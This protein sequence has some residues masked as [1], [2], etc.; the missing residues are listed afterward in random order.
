MTDNTPKK[1]RAGLYAALAVAVAGIGWAVF[2]LKSA[3]P[4]PVKIVPVAS[5]PAAKPSPATAFYIDGCE[6][7]ARAINLRAAKRD[8]RGQAALGVDPP[9]GWCECTGAILGSHFEPETVRGVGEWFQAV[10]LG[11]A[12]RSSEDAYFSTFSPAYRVRIESAY[13]FASRQCNGRKSG[14]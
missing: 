13:D 5:Y 8:A 6:Q 9:R 4:Q 3:P 14:G 11:G 10:A 1:S 7:R 2:A 12:E